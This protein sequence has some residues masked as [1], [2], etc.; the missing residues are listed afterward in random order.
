MCHAWVV[1]TGVCTFSDVWSL[2]VWFNVCRCTSVY[3]LSKTF[4]F[5]SKGDF[6][7]LFSI[8][9]FTPLY[10]L[11]INHA[12]GCLCKNGFTIILSLL[13]TFVNAKFWVFLI[14]IFTKKYLGCSSGRTL[15]HLK[16][17]KLE[18]K[19]LS[20]V[21]GVDGKIH[22]EGVVQHRRWRGLPSHRLA[23]RSQRDGFSHPHQEHMIDTF[24]C[25]FY[26]I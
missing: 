2:P 1:P 7:T 19:Y 22:P 24:S 20:C 11:F 8:G 21:P 6:N 13:I 26:F 23:A 3:L 18:Y 5:Y 12:F 16:I 10:I 9:V 14:L 4:I 15:F 17:Y 25:I